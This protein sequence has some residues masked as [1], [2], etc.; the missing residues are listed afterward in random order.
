MHISGIVLLIN[1][2]P[3]FS[4]ETINLQ[5]NQQNIVK[6]NNSVFQ[7]RYINYSSHKKDGNLDIGLYE[8]SLNSDGLHFRQSLQV[9]GC[10]LRVLFQHGLLV[11]YHF[12]HHCVGR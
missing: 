7:N 12:L 11:H 5:L 4:A 10:L 9:L 8:I 6:E 2:S 3:W 1:I